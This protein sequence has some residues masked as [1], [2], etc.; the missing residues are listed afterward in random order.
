MSN[1]ERKDIL[2]SYKL[3]IT[4]NFVPFSVSR[5]RD[6]KHP[7]L[8][9]LVTLWF[10][11]KPIITTDFM[12]GS[13]HCPSRKLKLNE[14]H[15]GAKERLHERYAALECETGKVVKSIYHNYGRGIPI[16][17]DI[18]SF[19]S[20]MLMDMDVMEYYTFEDWANSMGYE[21]DSRKA[22]AIYNAC[23]KQASELSKLPKSVIEELRKA[24][25]NY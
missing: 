11:D 13:G 12:M 10:V 9:W 1:E 20:C 16:Q 25:E 14:K 22:E 7:S 23:R 24:Y 6:E 2:D 15:S 21:E 19:L 8:N 4:A 5:N 17:P 18:D 3:R